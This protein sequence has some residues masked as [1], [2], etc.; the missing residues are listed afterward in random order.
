MSY[1]DLVTAIEAESKELERLEIIVKSM[2][3][4]VETTASELRH[5]VF[6]AKQKAAK[7]FQEGREELASVNAPKSAYDKLAKIQKQGDE[8]LKRQDEKV[9][10]EIKDLKAKLAT[11]RV[12]FDELIA[13]QREVLSDL[14][15]RRDKAR[16]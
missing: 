1:T 11:E 6:D 10:S 13:K 7:H 5:I 2:E 8:E 15:A 4:K 16:P 12:P 9:T 14:R 3:D